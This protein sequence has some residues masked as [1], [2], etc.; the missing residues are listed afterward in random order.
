MKLKV[1]LK[2]K[3]KVKVKVKIKVEIKVKVKVEVEV[4]SKG[5]YTILYKVKTP[6]CDA[7]CATA[8]PPSPSCAWSPSP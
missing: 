4:V 2:V 1:K 8:R 7:L 5:P 6:V 3:V